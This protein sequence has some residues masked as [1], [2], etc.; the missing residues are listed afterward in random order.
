MCGRLANERLAC[1]SSLH[2]DAYDDYDDDCC[3]HDDDDDHYC[4]GRTA[5]T[6]TKTTAR[7]CCCCCCCGV[8]VSA[9]NLP[10]GLGQQVASLASCHSVSHSFANCI[11]LL[12][13]KC[14]AANLLRRPLLP[15]LLLRSFLA[16]VRLLSCGHSGFFFFFPRLA[17]CRPTILSIMP[18]RA[19]LFEPNVRRWLLHHRAS[20]SFLTKPPCRSSSR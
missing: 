11:C 19:E 20:S 7:S 13:N 8:C 3:D 16:I 2:L 5:K 6:K 15:L 4:D 1:I 18:S 17:S 14:C 12:H 9:A 10:L